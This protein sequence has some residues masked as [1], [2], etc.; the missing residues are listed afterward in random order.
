MLGG[1]SWQSTA[2][3]YRLA[4]EL[5]RERSGGRHSARVVLASLDFAE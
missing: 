4:N 5:A 3:Y 2:E 1:M